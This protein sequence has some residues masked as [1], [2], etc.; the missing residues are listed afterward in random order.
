[1]LSWPIGSLTSGVGG[2]RDVRTRSIA[3]RPPKPPSPSGEKNASPEADEACI[4]E[5]A[6]TTLLVV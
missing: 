4:R 1:M 6:E 2:A 3:R 5:D